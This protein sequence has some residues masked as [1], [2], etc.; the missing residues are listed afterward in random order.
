[1]SAETPK[2]GWPAARSEL[3]RFLDRLPAAAY[4]CDPEGLI[5]YFNEPALELWG[6]APRLN[7]PSNRFC[8]SWGLF[9]IAGARVAVDRCWMALALK[10]RTPYCGREIVI[11]RPDGSRREALAHANPMYVEHGH[12]IGAVNVLLDITPRRRAEGLIRDAQRRHDEVLAALA[13]AVRNPLTPLSAGIAIVRNSISDP[14]TILEHCALM[15]TQ[16]QQLTRLVDE[17]LDVSLVTQRKLRLEKRRIA[18]K[19]IVR[20]AVEENQASIAQARHTLSVSLPAERIFVEADPLRLG[21]AVS[22][23]LSNAAKYTP[24]GGRIELAVARDNG[25]VRVSVRDTGVG[26]AADKL[27]AVFEAFDRVDRSLQTGHEGLGIGLTLVKALVEMH[28]GTVQAHSEG[29]GKGSEFGIWLPVASPASTAAAPSVAPAR[30]HKTR[31]V[32]LVDDNAAVGRALSRLVRMLGHDVRVAFDGQEALRAAEEFQP[33]IVLMDIGL[34][35]LSGY[36]AAREIRARRG[37]SVTLIAVT[38]WGGEA[39]RRRSR[40]AGFD[41]HLTK[42]V[43][44]SLLADVLNG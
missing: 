39:D 30:T 10:E 19:T 32:L 43:E 9:S 26:I 29:L 6:R 18:L 3:R 14:E 41:R 2:A 40:E 38:G 35:R 1:M 7:D 22:G 34:P 33:E 12:L 20:T 31:R 15:E 16:L 11:E 28:G 13:H 17:L 44:A 21:Q 4:T 8:G 36:D 5:T 27:D 24:G 23:L 42:P 25:G 37:Q